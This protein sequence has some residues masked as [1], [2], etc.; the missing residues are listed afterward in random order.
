VWFENNLYIDIAEVRNIDYMEYM[1]WTRKKFGKNSNEYNRIL[2]DTNVWEESLN[3]YYLRHPSYRDYPI[4]GVSYQQAVDYCKWRSDRVNEY[5]YFKTNKLEYNSDTT[6]SD[7]PQIYT[8]SLPSTELFKELL[9]IKNSESTQKKID[10]K[11][12]VAYNYKSSKSTDSISSNAEHK[13][14][15]APVYAYYPNSLGLYNLRG[16]VAEITT[17]KGVALGGS[18]LNTK[19]E[20]ESGK[21]LHFSKPKKWLGFRCVCKVNK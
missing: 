21:E 7:I 17:T 3:L 19:Q 18:Y 12:L 5:Y 13:L 6:Y 9:T 20:I 1:Y 15:L 10:K 8:Y 11:N 16:N 4:V 14:L 2:P